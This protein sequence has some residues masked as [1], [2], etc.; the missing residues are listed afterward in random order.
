MILIIDSYVTQALEPASTSIY[1]CP[2]KQ[3]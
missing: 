2:G 1:S 3:W